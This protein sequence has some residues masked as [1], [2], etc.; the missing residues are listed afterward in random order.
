MKFENLMT[1]AQFAEKF[2]L[3]LGNEH[4]VQWYIRRHRQ[5]LLEAG[6]FVYLQKRKL[7]NLPEFERF[8]EAQSKYKPEA[9]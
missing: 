5:A 3:V 6:A 2:P 1:P 9:A 4:G 8:V 7:I